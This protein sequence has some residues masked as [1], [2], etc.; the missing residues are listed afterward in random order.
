M[1]CCV[2]ASLSTSTYHPDADPDSY[3]LFD[4]PDVDPDPTYNP[5]TDPDS[6]PSL[7]KRLK[8]LEEC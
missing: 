8:P 2:S 7:K 3:F 6:D 4:Y 1:Q 5:D